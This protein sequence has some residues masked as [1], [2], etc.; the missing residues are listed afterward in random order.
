[1]SLGGGE[2]QFNIPCLTLSL[3]SPKNTVQY[4]RQETGSIQAH[5]MASSPPVQ[6][7]N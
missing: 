2:T 6:D 3:L 5:G 7:T 1:M 4:T